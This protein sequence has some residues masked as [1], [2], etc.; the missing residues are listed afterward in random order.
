[1]LLLASD[2]VM[3]DILIKLKEYKIDMAN[4]KNPGLKTYTLLLFKT[5]YI[6]PTKYMGVLSIYLHLR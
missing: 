2:L 6:T 1:M 3:Q 5:C 4:Q